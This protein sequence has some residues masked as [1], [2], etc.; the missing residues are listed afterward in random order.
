MSRLEHHSQCPRDEIRQAR[1]DKIL[2]LLLLLPDNHIIPMAEIGGPDE[3][4]RLWRVNRTIHEL[5]KDRVQNS[6]QST[7][8]EF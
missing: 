7:N 5:V 6:N 8:S 2:S 4:A 3:A 1:D